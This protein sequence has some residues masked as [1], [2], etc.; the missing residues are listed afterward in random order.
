MFDSFIKLL[1]FACLKA[2]KRALF[3]AGVSNTHLY[4]FVTLLFSV[5]TKRSTFRKRIQN[6]FFLLETGLSF[7]FILSDEKDEIEHDRKL[8]TVCSWKTKDE[9]R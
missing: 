5:S 8:M 4:V 3:V 7:G 9:T 6:G 2:C 1:S